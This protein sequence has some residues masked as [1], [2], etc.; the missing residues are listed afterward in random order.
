MLKTFVCEY[1]GKEYQADPDLGVWQ[2]DDTQKKSQIGVSCKRYCCY[3]C[4]KKARAEKVSAQWQ[5]KSIDEVN[6]VISKRKKAVKPRICKVCGKEFI[7]N[8]P[9]GNA[10]GVYLCSDE[11]REKHFRLIPDSGIKKCQNCGKEYH[12]ESGQGSWDKDNNLVKVN[13]LGHEFV[14]K[15]HR[16][17]CYE[18]GIKYKERK[19]KVSNIV[20]YGRVSPFQDTDFRKNLIE[21]QK[22]NGTLFVSKGE[23]EIKDWLES[24]GVK[25]EHYITG[26]GLN[27]KTPRIE[28]DIYIPDLK[29]GIEYNGVYYH[30]VNG[31]KKDRIN[32]RYHYNKS[33]W[34]QEN[35]IELI[36]VWEDQWLNKKEL[37]KSIL[38][39]R[40]NL[41]DKNVN[42]IYARNCELRVLSTEKYREFCE[43]NHIQGYKKASIKLGLF[44]KDELVQIASF[45]KVN[46]RGK[47][48][49]TNKNYDYEW[50]RGCPASLNYVVG[51]TSKL[52]KYFIKNYTPSSVLCYAD[53]NLF[54]GRGYK[55]CGFELMGYT[56]PDKFYVT[57]DHHYIRKGRDPYNY[58]E[59]MNLVQSNKLWLCYGA[60][61]MRFIWTK[62]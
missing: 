17:C 45:G 58:K 40:L 11:C 15:S 22:E 27:D 21:K 26:N 55:E 9:T 18:C 44:Y 34:A 36:H 31:I 29:I 1:C 16:F 8:G 41:I 7:P 39:A 50:V 43:L 42:R 25:T 13:G 3:K 49:T 52:F 53:W 35:G 12:Y 30:S 14:V 10:K 57:A 61:S 4:G 28:I 56:G 23:Q 5:N 32:T 38:K 46:N 51:G 6:A 60:G 54:N 24:L 33:K 37:V 48:V 59:L 62:N 20:K 47:A 2:K 19:R